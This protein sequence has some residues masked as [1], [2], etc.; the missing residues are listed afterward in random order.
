MDVFRDAFALPLRDE[1][2]FAEPPE[3]ERDLLAAVDRFFVAEAVDFELRFDEVREDAAVLEPA[4]RFEP[5]ELELFDALFFEE[6]ADFDAVEARVERLADFA[7]AAR[8]FEPERLLDFRAAFVL[9]AEVFDDLR[10]EAA[11]LPLLFR[12]GLPD[13]AEGR[14]AADLVA[15]RFFALALLLALFPLFRALLREELAFTLPRLTSFEKRLFFSSWKRNASPSLS[16]QSNHW[17]HS[18]RSSDSVPL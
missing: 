3:V 12:D 5:A 11:L 1:A 8:F 2:R 13:L 9:R 15:A 16:N 18:I 10:D 4:A 17:S 14:D 7:E 6:F